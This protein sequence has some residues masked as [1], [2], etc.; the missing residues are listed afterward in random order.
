MIGGRGGARAQGFHEDINPRKIAKNT[1][2][3]SI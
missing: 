1:I 3:Y 2:Y